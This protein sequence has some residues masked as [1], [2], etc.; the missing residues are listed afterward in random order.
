MHCNP[1][2]NSCKTFGENDA[3]PTRGIKQVFR[4][5]IWECYCKDAHSS[6][7]QNTQPNNRFAI[8]LYFT[9]ALDLRITREVRW[10]TITNKV[11]M[12]HAFKA[13]RMYLHLRRRICKTMN[14]HYNG[15][16][17]TKRIKIDILDKTLSS[18]VLQI[19][20]TCDRLYMNVILDI[21]PITGNG[22][23]ICRRF[24]PVILHIKMKGAPESV[25]RRK[26]TCNND[27]QNDG[28]RRSTSIRRLLKTQGPPT[29]L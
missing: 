14:F 1:M 20:F 12:T 17:S 10:W 6:D 18:T 3:Q 16:D 19:I 23:L 29:R 11:F 22:T 27:I 28:Y 7:E 15:D 8:F 24:W 21:V 5:W 26:K 2:L 25:S 9:G 13:T 4:A